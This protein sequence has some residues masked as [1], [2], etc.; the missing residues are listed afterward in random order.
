MTC[1]PAGGCPSALVATHWPARVVGGCAYHQSWRPKLGCWLG[2][3]KPGPAHCAANNCAG[4]SC[5]SRYRCSDR[6][7]DCSPPEWMA[8][9]GLRELCGGNVVWRQRRVAE[10]PC[11]GKH[12]EVGHR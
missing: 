9:C 5:G 10:M 6:V 4:N 2:S 8:E 11:G 12:G 3:A 7:P 1:R